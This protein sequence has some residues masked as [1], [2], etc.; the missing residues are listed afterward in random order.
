MKGDLFSYLKNE[1]NE[2]SNEQKL[3]WMIEIC[4]GMIHLIENKIVHRDLAARNCLLN[5]PLNIK[6]SDFGLARIMDTNNQVYSK[7]EVG[8]LVKQQQFN[9]LLFKPNFFVNRN[10]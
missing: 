9:H 8:P 10:G 4:N 7:S 1:K 5:S 2:I 6:I 3:K